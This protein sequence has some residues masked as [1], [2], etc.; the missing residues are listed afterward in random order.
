MKTYYIKN[1]DCEN[2]ARKI[3]NQIARK[4]RASE[5]TI[6][7]ISSK[8]LISG[9]SA[10][11][12]ELTEIANEVENGVLIYNEK[13]ATE[14]ETEDV[15]SKKLISL[16]IGFG[17]LGLGIISNFDY[18]YLFGYLV[19]GYPVIKLALKNMKQRQFFDEY[20][21]MAIATL[22]AIS[23]NQ[24]AE[25][26]AVMLF[27]SVGE[28]VQARTLDKTKL[29][30]TK[31]A[32]LN[33]RNA[34]LVTE[35]GTRE[36]LTEDLEVGDVIKVASG[37]RIAVD[38]KLISSHGYIDTSHISGESEP[39][40]INAD[41]EVFG[42]SV[43]CGDELLLEV[44]ARADDS[45]IAKL[46]ELVTYADSKKTKTEQFMTRFSRIYTPIVVAMAVGIV[47]LFPPIFGITYNDA[48]YRAVTLLVI[49]CPCAFVL[50]VPLGYVV[51]IG[52]LAK[53]HILVKGSIAVDRLKQVNVIAVDKTGTLTTGEFAV[54]SFTNNSI[55]T[56]D[57]IHGLIYS[58]EENISHPIARSLVKFTK[59]YSG[60]QV[61]EIKQNVG[62]GIS[63]LYNGQVYLLEKGDSDQAVTVSHLYE[64]ES[65]IATYRMQDEVKAGV[66]NLTKKLKKLDVRMLMLTG[67]N[68][69]VADKVAAEIGM[70]PGDVYSE[71]L[72]E[73]KLTIVEKEI[74]L[75]RVVAFIGDGLNDAAVIK[76]SDLGIAMGARGSELSIDSSDVVISDDQIGKIVD[77]I[78]ISRYSSK[79]I[80]Q[81]IILAFAV[82][83]LFITLG[84]FGITT[85]WEAVFSDVGVTLIAIANSMRIKRK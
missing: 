60:L 56:D 48:I 82:K 70:E 10:T 42:G 58:A 78:Y 1:V 67:D 41:D 45:M 47:V 34:I 83:I 37:E 50:S 29:S 36:V 15:M 64:G 71:L 22:A 63:F 57:F 8:L 53:E 11:A 85:M 69:F 77:A 65:L 80:I 73:D 76:R 20:F 6:N 13:N 7:L 44:V 43:N 2:C 72:P 35:E 14:D 52:R 54:T 30:I 17:A 18:F 23:I 19:V 68:K 59:D 40:S 12:E 55:Y 38:S 66:R 49:S 25:A 16:G 46:I 84:I 62:R 28:Y 81:N 5:V 39:Q 61:D 32:E 21:L 31:L 75:G 33:V 51:A 24:W 74:N 27:Y 26:L 79:I 3:E 9:S 4:T